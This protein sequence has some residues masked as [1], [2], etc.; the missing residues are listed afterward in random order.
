MWKTSVENGLNLVSFIRGTA[1]LSVVINLPMFKHFILKWLI[2]LAR[3]NPKK[4]VLYEGWNTGK[5]Q[6]HFLLHFLRRI[7][8][9]TVLG[10]CLAFFRGQKSP[11]RGLEISS[12]VFGFFRRFSVH[13][14]P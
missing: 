9:Y 6:L 14:L 5:R 13:S 7:E 12:L 2:Q 4:G 11:F 10:I 8:I 3:Q 1:L